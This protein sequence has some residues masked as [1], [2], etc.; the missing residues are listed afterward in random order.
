MKK[1]IIELNVQVCGNLVSVNNIYLIVEF[2]KLEISILIYIHIYS[3]T[4]ILKQIL[5]Y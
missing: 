2:K 5:L 1:Q 4:W 3:L